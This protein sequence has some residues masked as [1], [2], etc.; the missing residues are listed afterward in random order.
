M[1]VVLR[2]PTCGTTQGDPGTC[3]ACSD[4]EVRYFCTNH[5]GGVWL[6]GPVCGSCG[7]KFG[8]PPRKPPT[9]RTPSVLTPPAGAP[10]FRPPSRRAA[11]DPSSESA[12]G[13][14][15]RRAG[16]EEPVEPE[17]LP[18]TPSS[19]GELLKEMIEERA[20]GRA[21]YEVEDAW[22]RRPAEPRRSGL[23]LAGCLVRIVGLVF[24]LIAA[25]IIFLFLLF[26]SL[27]VN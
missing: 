19:L 4:G 3:E 13:R 21:R 22:A 8:D 6:N 27:I 5:D 11:T 17:L 1:S 26:G 2:C 10:D 18:R 23:P 15:P 7:A 14:R 9:P 12:L 24:L 16:P 20:R 25:A